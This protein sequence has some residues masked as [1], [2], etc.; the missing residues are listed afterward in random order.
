MLAKYNRNN[1]LTN[2]T[3]NVMSLSSLS[4]FIDPINIALPIPNIKLVDSA[5]FLLN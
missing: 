4:R 5:A 1:T 3:S 2:T